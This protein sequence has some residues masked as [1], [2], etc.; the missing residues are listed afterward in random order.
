M[1]PVP[2]RGAYEERRTMTSGSFLHPM[3]FPDVAIP[4]SGMLGVM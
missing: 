4:V 1:K 2:A 3:A